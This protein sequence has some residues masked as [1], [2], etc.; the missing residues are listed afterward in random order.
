[1]CFGVNTFTPGARRSTAPSTTPRT[2]PVSSPANN[3]LALRFSHQVSG[4]D[5][6]TDEILDSAINSLWEE[7]EDFC[8]YNSSFYFQ[9]SF[10][11]RRYIK[12][13]EV[14]D[15]ITVMRIFIARFTIPY[16]ET[17]L[18]YDEDGE[19]VVDENGNFKRKVDDTDEDAW[20]DLIEAYHNSIIDE[21]KEIA[22]LWLMPDGTITALAKYR[23]DIHYDDTDGFEFDTLF[24]PVPIEQIADVLSYNYTCYDDDSDDYA[25]IDNKTVIDHASCI[26]SMRMIELLNSYGCEVSGF[27][28]INSRIY[29]EKGNCF[30]H[31]NLEKLFSNYVCFGEKSSA[32]KHFH[33]IKVAT[34]NHYIPQDERLWL[35]VLDLITLCNGNIQDPRFYAPADLIEA[36]D[37]W[38]ARNNRRIEREHREADRRRQEAEEKRKIENAHLLAQQDA[39]YQSRRSIFRSIVIGNDKMYARVI[40]D[41]TEFYDEGVAQG[42]CIYNCGYFSFPDMLC[43]SVRDAKTHKRLSTVTYNMRLECI[44]ANLTKGDQVPEMFD[45]IEELILSHKDLIRRDWERCP[46]FIHPSENG[47]V[48]QQYAHE[49]NL[50]HRNKEQSQKDAILARRAVRAA[51]AALTANRP[52][53]PLTIAI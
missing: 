7:G 40:Q 45:E 51:K 20:E 48:R 12:K 25:F 35:E 33:T 31:W 5:C 4:I 21:K 41:V 28:D 34:R 17:G 3:E 9:A 22:Q 53:N 2:I 16:Y 44:E 37:Y 50:M 24:R 1:M 26:Q 27:D 13:M 47:L 42:F 10:G 18:E 6:R 30:K 43:F 32:F 39:D 14:I 49:W 29:D 8:S 52:T 46:D 36:Y 19:V 23:G 38:D 11:G 15:G